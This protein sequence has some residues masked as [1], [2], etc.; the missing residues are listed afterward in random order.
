MALPKPSP[1][2]TA[3]VTGASSGIGREIARELGRRGYGLTLVARRREK[4][5]ELAA[6]LSSAS[7]ARIEIVECD[8][9]DADARDRLEEDV[10]KCGL[11][12][13]VLVN[14]AGMGTYVP[15]ADSERERELQQVR[16]N[17]EAPVDLMARYLPGM[18]SRGRGAIV[19]ISS[20]SGLQPTPNNA[21]YA[22]S[23]S[24]LL[25][26]SEAVHAEVKRSGVTV[27][28]VLP[29]PV[30]TE[31]QEANG[32]AFA[33]KLPGFVWVPVERVA[34]DA[35]EAVEKG[36][37]TVIPGG[38][39]VRAAFGPNRFAPKAVVLAVGQRLMS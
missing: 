8:L 20:S 28:A 31:F 34:S 5:E 16:L 2:S 27:T 37:R 26:H 36:K 12:V 35:I 21:T 17:V 24:F 9:A 1:E 11:T 13:E 14:S 32:A 15:F 23:K 10:V 39:P 33:E 22:A 25:F 29:G 6:E 38:L 30:R 18:V 19:N 7:A 3:L 4:L